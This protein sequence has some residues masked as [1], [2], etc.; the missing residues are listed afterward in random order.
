MTSP[1][2]E[3][4]I[5]IICAAMAINKKNPQN[6]PFCGYGKKCTDGIAW[7]GKAKCQDRI[8]LTVPQWYRPPLTPHWTL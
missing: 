2:I 6:K 7:P 1:K 4:I 3:R 5:Q 8:A